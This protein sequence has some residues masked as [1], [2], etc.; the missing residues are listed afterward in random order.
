VFTTLEKMIDQADGQ[1]LRANDLEQL[2]S[3]SQSFQQRQRTYEQVQ[4]Q[5]SKLVAAVVKKLRLPK[6][7][8]DVTLM[9]RML[10]LAMLLEDPLY[11]QV[12]YLDW[13]VS[14]ATAFGTQ[15]RVQ[16][17]ALLLKTVLSER[18]GTQAPCFTPYLDQLT[19]AFAG[20]AR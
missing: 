2:L 10:A 7:S 3:Y 12:H 15:A 5:E 1:F 16:Q 19:Q 4:K 6:A 11:F 17:Q 14:Q 9:L 20:D 8:D 18:L 13:L